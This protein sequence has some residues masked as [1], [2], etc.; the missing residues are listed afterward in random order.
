MRI[1]PWAALVVALPIVSCAT[2]P[3]VAP[4]AG[5]SSVAAPGGGLAAA[6]RSGGGTEAAAGGSAESTAAAGGLAESKAEGR[7]GMS[8]R[9]SGPKVPA[10][11]TAAYVVFDRRAGKIVSHRLAHRAF[12][13]A[14]VIKIL[15]AIDFLERTPK[16]SAA[17]LASLKVMLR[18]SDDAAA[19]A[20]WDR[21]G[22]AE[23]V[24]R[25]AGKL[26]L[27]DTTPPPAYKP[28][29]WGY[30]SLSA[31]DV[32]RTYR[33]LLDR[34]APRVRDVIVGHLRNATRCG[35][36]GFDQSFGIPSGV[37]RPWAVKQGWS[38][39]GTVPP[40][41]CTSTSATP[42]GLHT[43]SEVPADLHT[44][45]LG[46]ASSGTV[47]APVG[48]GGVPAVAR[49]GVPDLGRPVLHTTGFLGKDDRLIMVLLTAHPAGGTWKDSVRRTT[50]LT[51]D[52]YRGVSAGQ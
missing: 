7:G 41:K 16:V 50:T 20:F 31:Y 5:G 38:G 19:S 14:S 9:G 13:S 43:A 26:G 44:T 36:D 42:A 6:A 51:R 1:K 17:D 49:P 37:P 30:A 23:I 10:G 40:V 32:A 46:A 39:F 52:L 28:G 18:S 48:N 21:G 35:T 24:K 4:A 33:Y 22:K 29:F 8:V 15:I 25:V 3:S 12:R 47:G 27:A 45:A 2:D 11:T 34:A